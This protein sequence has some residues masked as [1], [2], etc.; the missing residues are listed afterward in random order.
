MK[1]LIL[2]VAAG[3]MLSGCINM[4]TRMPGTKAKITD[5]YQSTKQAAAMSVV[6]AFPQIM[7]SSGGK[8][9]YWENLLTVPLG[10]MVGVDALAEACID[11]V[12][13][14][15]DWPVSAARNARFKAAGLGNSSIDI[16]KEK[17]DSLLIYG[18]KGEDYVRVE[19]TY[20]NGEV[21]TI[22][23]PLADLEDDEEAK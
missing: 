12:C 18:Y 6:V 10:L 13:L 14:P 9:F 22:K 11:T 23:V 4:Y 21:E 19:T 16:D 2:V 5:I 8:G 3:L 20:K 17:V 7:A 1:K 15:Y